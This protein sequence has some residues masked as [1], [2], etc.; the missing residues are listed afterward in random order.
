MV[1]NE[2]FPRIEHC[3]VRAEFEL[4][5][6]MPDIAVSTIIYDH[7]TIRAVVMIEKV[8]HFAVQ[9]CLPSFRRNFKVVGLE[10]EFI[11]KGL[12]QRVDLGLALH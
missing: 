10:L 4:A 2:G 6:F 9:C 1:S 12:P 7:Q 8:R 5:C 3:S 11:L